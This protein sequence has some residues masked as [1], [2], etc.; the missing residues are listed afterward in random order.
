M[1]CRFAINL[2]S[3]LEIK[4]LYFLCIYAALKFLLGE[5]LLVRSNFKELPIKILY[6]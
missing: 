5:L 4:L 6:K 1:D 3:S 2:F